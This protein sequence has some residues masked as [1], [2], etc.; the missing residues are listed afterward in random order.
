MNISPSR[1][2]RV[3]SPSRTGSGGIQRASIASSPAS[4]ERRAAG[5]SRSDVIARV[6]MTTR[7]R[8]AALVASST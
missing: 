6:T 5:M 3:S 7:R 2:R 4:S 8:L 1:N